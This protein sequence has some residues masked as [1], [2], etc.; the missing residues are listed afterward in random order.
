MIH[1]KATTNQQPIQAIVSFLS[2]LFSDWDI[3]LFSV[4][5]GAYLRLISIENTVRPSNNSNMYGLGNTGSVLA[6]IANEKYSI[7]P[8]I[9][10]R[11]Y[12]V[13]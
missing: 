3:G 8:K 12:E 11:L 4:S 6:T 2:L 9:K 10:Q 1:N 5:A 7:I 13:Q